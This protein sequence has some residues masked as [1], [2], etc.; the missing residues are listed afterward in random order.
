[1]STLAS[2]MTPTQEAW[3]WVLDNYGYIRNLTRKY[4]YLTNY[5]QSLEDSR[6]DACIIAFGAV[7]GW[8]GI[9]SIKGYVAVCIRRA[10]RERG[11]YGVGHSKERPLYL[12]LFLDNP[13]YAIPLLDLDDPAVI[14]E[15]HELLDRYRQ[16]WGRFHEASNVELTLRRK[17]LQKRLTA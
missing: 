15:E 16:S 3:Q 1:M 8:N 4:Q 11:W 6:Q 7:K 17:F 9:G 2:R 12:E 14:A 13:N 5:Q 10:L